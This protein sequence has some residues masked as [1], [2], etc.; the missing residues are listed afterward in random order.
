MQGPRYPTPTRHEDLAP[1]IRRVRAPNPSPMTEAGT[2]SYI[3]GARDVAI[4]DPGPMNEAHAQALLA[5]LH[6]G[7]RVIAIVVTHRHADHAGL[8]HVLGRQC[9]AAVMAFDATRT[10]APA[11]PQAL[12]G[13]DI[14]GGEGIEPDF[15]ADEHLADG[16][17]LRL[18]GGTLEALHTPGHLDDHLCL[19]WGDVLLSGDHVMGWAPSLVSPPDGDMHAYMTSLERLA[20]EDAALLLPGHGAPI[21]DPAARIAELRA[22]RLGRE[23]SVRAAISGGSATLAEVTA[24]VYGAMPPGLAAAAARNALAHLI[25]LERRGEAAI[26]R[27]DDAKDPSSLRFS[28]R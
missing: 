20:R 21:T 15:T 27:A 16:Q 9:G 6:P 22:H 2:N 23:A 28:R 26:T 1:G 4:V 14:G 18:G 11:L 10:K 25:D 3:I 12:A 5:A 13:I 24:A 17:A 19:R 8:A 7:E